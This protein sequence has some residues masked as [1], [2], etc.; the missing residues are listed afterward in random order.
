MRLFAAQRK[1]E[2][3]GRGSV[4]QTQVNQQCEGV[5]HKSLFP[6]FLK[7]QKRKALNL[8]FQ[9]KFLEQ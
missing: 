1:R 5:S 9:W 4:K 2:A 6:H 7:R 3:L 8:N